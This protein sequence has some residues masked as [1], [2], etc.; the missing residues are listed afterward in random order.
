[1]HGSSSFALKEHLLQKSHMVYHWT[2]RIH[3]IIQIEIE[4]DHLRQVSQKIRQIMDDFELITAFKSCFVTV[5]PS[6]S[7]FDKSHFNTQN[8]GE[9]LVASSEA[10]SAWVQRSSYTKQAVQVRE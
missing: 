9:I 10:Q 5:K 8:S 1:M 2:I 7:S 4:I 6:F 3:N